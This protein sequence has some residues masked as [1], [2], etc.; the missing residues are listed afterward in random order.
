VVGES[1]V[2][3]LI[4]DDQQVIGTLE[5]TDQALVPESFAALDQRKAA[6]PES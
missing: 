1:P 3:A 5:H 6:V 2:E 4:G